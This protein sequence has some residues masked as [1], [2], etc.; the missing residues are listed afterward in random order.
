MRYLLT[1]KLDFVFKRLFVEDTEIL[2]DLVNRVLGLPESGRIRSVEVRNPTI[3][4]EEIGKK[5]IILD[6]LASDEMKNQ[7]DIEMQARKY[8]FY[9]ERALYYLCRM[10]SE[11]LESGERYDRL[12][13]GI[14]IHFL[15]YEMFPEEDDFQ[16]QF[17]MT[18]VRH[19]KLRL[20][21]NLSLFL[22]ELPKP[23][24]KECGDRNAAGLLE[25]I[26][27]FNHAPD[28]EDETMRTHYT[29]PMIHRAFDVLTRLSA[30]EE[31]R[32]LAQ[33]REKA[34][35]DEVSMLYA[36]RKEGEKKGKKEGKK[37]GREETAQN[38]LSMGVLTIEQI[39]RAAGLSVA[40]V[41]RLQELEGENGSQGI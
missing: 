10:Y 7:Y 9:P 11:Q 38:L 30:D 27:F 20:T 40:E 5:F 36:A 21:D 37:E 3:L 6:I 41:E 15:D 24:K 2:A 14:G 25:W 16:F 31:T 18:D 12:R 8:A 23:E 26:H 17:E 19:P 28:E 13:P 29:N 33:M 1:P 32:R 35:K 22:L 39:A 34:L 4:P